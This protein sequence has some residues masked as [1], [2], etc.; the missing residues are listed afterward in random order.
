MNL[1]TLSGA[2]SIALVSTF[3]FLLLAKSW[4]AIARSVGSTSSF[5]DSIMLE[6]AQRFRDETDLLSRRL[7]V[8]LTSA[9]VF[10]V[11]FAV[12]YI[13]RAG[14]V[15]SD[16]ATGSNS[17]RLVVCFAIHG[18]PICHCAAGQTPH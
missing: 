11:I 6:A 4:H 18:L 7:H 13:L 1:E 8:Y 5:A 15:F 10:A 12:S 17:R 2:A 14:E 3:V 16:L 9:F